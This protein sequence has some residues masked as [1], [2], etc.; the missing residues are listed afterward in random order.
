MENEDFKGVHPGA[1]NV[2]KYCVSTLEANAGGSNVNAL[3]HTISLLK[4]VISVFPKSQVKSSCEMVLK[5]MA[6]GEPRALTCGFQ[7]LYGLF[8]GR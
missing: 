8:A 1:S 4:D 2:A 6:S 7:V 5:I 3:L